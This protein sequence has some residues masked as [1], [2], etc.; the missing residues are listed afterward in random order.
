MSICKKIK[1]N[2][3]VLIMVKMCPYVVCSHYIIS[4]FIIL[5]SFLRFFLKKNKK[6]L[7]PLFGGLK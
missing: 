5:V 1:K 6:N 2:F 3:G 4:S 7:V